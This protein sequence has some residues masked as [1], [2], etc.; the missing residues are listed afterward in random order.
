MTLVSVDSAGATPD[1][2]TG[3]LVMAIPGGVDRQGIQDRLDRISSRPDWEQVLADAAGS[4]E[5]L[6][7]VAVP[8]AA[9]SASIFGGGPGAESSDDLPPPTPWGD[10]HDDRPPPMPWD[11]GTP[12]SRPTT[13]RIPRFGRGKDKPPPP[14]PPARSDDDDLP[15]MPDFL[16]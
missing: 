13:A 8:S 15:P 10:P 5:E 14:P 4:E 1:E 7:P 12:E 2:A 3:N 11:Q 9:G 6:T 16:K